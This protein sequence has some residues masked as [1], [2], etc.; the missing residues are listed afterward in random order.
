LHES[1]DR[2]HD[3]R[4]AKDRSNSPAVI[5]ATL[6]ISS[7]SFYRYLGEGPLK[8]RTPPVS[9]AIATLASLA[10]E[11]TR[12]ARRPSVGPRSMTGRSALARS[13]MVGAARDDVAVRDRRQASEVLGQN[14]ASV[15]V[16]KGSLP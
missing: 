14:G 12:R 8:R 9:P 2:H 10:S 1:I 5:C 3:Q 4:L 16:A 6:G 15:G 7:P 13:K 11:G